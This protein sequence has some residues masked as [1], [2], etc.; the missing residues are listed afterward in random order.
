MFINQRHS[1]HV[2]SL[3]HAIEYTYIIIYQ[4]VRG[5]ANAAYCVTQIR[6]GFD[7]LTGYNGFPTEAELNIKETANG[8]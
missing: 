6:L 8:N 4:W 5:A 3:L 2:Y 1:N 7:Q